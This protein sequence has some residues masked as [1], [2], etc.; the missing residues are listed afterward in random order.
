MVSGFIFAPSLLISV[1]KK[2]K[3]PLGTSIPTALAI[4]NV[5][6]AH[7]TMGLWWASTLD[8]ITALLWV[9]LIFRRN[10]GTNKR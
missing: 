7:A 10:S 8:L 2:S 1:I 5:G 6:I 9:I 4:T 3:L